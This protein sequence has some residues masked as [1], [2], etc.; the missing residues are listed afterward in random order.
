MMNIL[1]NN[2]IIEKIGTSL[3]WL[4][5][6]S[7]FL[8]G[9][10]R[11]GVGGALFLQAESFL[12]LQPLQEVVHETQAFIDKR[13]SDQLVGFT[14]PVYFLYIFAMGLI[15]LLGVLGVIKRQSYGFYCLFTYLIMHALLFINFQEINPK[16][17]GLAAA[18][19][20]W[21]VL[22]YVRKPTRR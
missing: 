12:A 21:V 14:T 15:L 7:F 20:A 16:L 4:I 5:I 17:T 10:V 19:A 6:L 3:G 9:V 22:Y 2:S 13:K 18:T 1:G 11:V 8:F